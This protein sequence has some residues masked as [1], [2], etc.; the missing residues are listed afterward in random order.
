M[1][2]KNR[3]FARVVLSNDSLCECLG[4]VQSKVVVLPEVNAIGWGRGDAFA[5]ARD[6]LYVRAREPIWARGEF[7]GEVA[8]ENE[9]RGH[10]CMLP[11][12]RADPYVP[13]R[14]RTEKFVLRL[15]ASCD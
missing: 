7:L 15:R 14:I 12:T 3:V 10:G 9:G 1:V 13:G 2:C 11:L 4:I 8:E 5:D 6:K